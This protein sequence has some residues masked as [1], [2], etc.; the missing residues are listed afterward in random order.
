MTFEWLNETP[1]EDWTVF[2]KL[3]RQTFRLTLFKKNSSI[4]DDPT[5]SWKSIFDRWGNAQPCRYRHFST[6]SVKGVATIMIVQNAP[7]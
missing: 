6:P 3:L 7:S 2:G 5:E 4:A 1:A